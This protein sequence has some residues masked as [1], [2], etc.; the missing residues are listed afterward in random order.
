M[1][2][3]PLAFA[4]LL[5]GGV[6][7]TAGISGNSVADV[8]AGAVSLKRLDVS[9]AG[10]TSV[11]APSGAANPFALSSGLKVGRV[12]QGV[13]ASMTPGSPIVAPLPSKVVRIDPNWYAG[14]PAVFFQ[15]TSGPEKGKYWYLGEQIAPSVK[16][17]DSVK[18]GDQVATYAS[19]GT[20]IE[21][22]WA[23]D[24]ANT[25]AQKT[26][27]YVEGQATTAGQ[28]FMGFLRGLGVR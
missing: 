28:D 27:G 6:L 20:G 23:A 8:F 21:I 10:G 24:A 12:D 15:V 14:Q 25:L 5:G 3:L 22:G 11:A 9:G 1:A 17:G 19:H 7:L 2:N 13:D 16:L 18:A 4:E 26:T